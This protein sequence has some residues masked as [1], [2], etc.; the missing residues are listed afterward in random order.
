VKQFQEVDRGVLVSDAAVTLRWKPTDT[1]AFIAPD[2]Q[3]GPR[4]E[5]E[6]EG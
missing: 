6:T 2:G 1:S 3:P 5:A 4:G